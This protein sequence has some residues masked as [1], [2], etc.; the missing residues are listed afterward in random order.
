MNDRLAVLDRLNR[1][2]RVYP[3]ITADAGHAGPSSGGELRAASL[4]RGASDFPRVLTGGY[5]Q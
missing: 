4:G 2:P 5:W 1:V 3:H